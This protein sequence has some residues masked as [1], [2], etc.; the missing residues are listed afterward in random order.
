MTRESLFRTA[1]GEL[2]HAAKFHVRGGEEELRSRIRT[3]RAHARQ[4]LGAAD[5]LEAPDPGDGSNLLY[6]AEVAVAAL[7]NSVGESY[8]A[9]DGSDLAVSLL[10]DAISQKGGLPDGR[11]IEGVP[12]DE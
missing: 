4:A 2:G 7:R 11:D 1:L 9:E 8:G 3:M 12:I 10:Q 6:A 5:R